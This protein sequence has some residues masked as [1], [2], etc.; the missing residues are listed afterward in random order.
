VIGELLDSDGPEE[1]RARR[2]EYLRITDKGLTYGFMNGMRPRGVA[3]FEG[4]LEG[5]TLSGKMR[6]GGISFEE[7]DGAPPL[8][9][10][11][12]RVGTPPK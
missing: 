1:L 5:D 9:F 2:V 4:K 7:R 3:L 8:R 10:S 6:F 11:F 12:K